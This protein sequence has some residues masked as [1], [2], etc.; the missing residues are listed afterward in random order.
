MRSRLL[1][2]SQLE[3]LLA[4]PTLD[5]LTQALGHTPYGQP[6][7]EALTRF[8]GVRAVDEALARQFHQT[9]TKILSFADGKPRELIEIVLMRWDLA[10][11]RVILRGKHSG[12]STDEIAG[13]LVPAGALSEVALRELVGQPDVAGV[14]GA[15]GGL[16]HP[17][18]GALA[19]GLGEY[20]ETHDLLALELRLDRFYAAYGLR[21]AAG[22]GQ[23]EQVLRRLLESEID[24]TN[25]KTALKLQPAGQLSGADR[26]R[27]FIPGGPLVSA[28]LFLALADPATAEQGM[29]GLRVRGFP[30]RG[31]PDDPAGFE[32]ELDLVM[33]R[34]QTSLYRGDPLAL[35][36]VI[37][38]LALKHNEVVNLRLIARSAALGIPRDRVRK[39][40]VG[41]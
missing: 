22:R 29:Q 40:M 13:N 20:Q 39:E 17:M 14:V 30:V 15:L 6:I 24:A 41:V 10:N 19:E 5:A 1:E 12:R 26:L 16:D 11:L 25:V 21:K 31:R 8:T 7:Q 27:F 38:Y 32:R 33:M 23:S 28:K 2:T 34:A 35:D 37:G 36:I 4:L 9:T 18:A 3:E